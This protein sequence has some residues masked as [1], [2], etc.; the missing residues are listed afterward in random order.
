MARALDERDQPMGGRARELADKA[1]ARGQM[2]VRR[3]GA[4][5][6]DPTT[7]EAWM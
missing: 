2:W 3:L 4:A 7:R 5:P 1:I 6:S